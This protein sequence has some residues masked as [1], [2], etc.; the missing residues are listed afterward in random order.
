M[1][2]RSPPEREFPSFPRVVRHGARGARSIGVLFFSELIYIFLMRFRI[3]R[4]RSTDSLAANR[5]AAS[6]LLALLLRP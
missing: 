3:S 2:L 4:I 6:L 5:P 1:R